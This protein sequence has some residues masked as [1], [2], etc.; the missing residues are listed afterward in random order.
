MKI[1]LV[2]KPIKLKFTF[3]CSLVLFGCT[4][5]QVRDFEQASAEQKKGHFRKAAQLYDQV[6]GRDSS[7]P[8][9]IEAMKE[10]ARITFLEIKDYARAAK[11]YKLV[12][13]HSPEENDRMQAQLQLASLYFEGLQ[14]YANAAIEF[15][16]LAS[17]TSI[18]SERAAHKLSVARSYYYIGNYFQTLS[19]ISEILKLKSDKETEFQAFKRKRFC[20]TEKVYGS[21]QTV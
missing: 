5:S 12:I 4:N 19:E 20:S 6:I 17:S 11:Y 16:K 1:V 18:E 21:R 2:K 13:Q 10:P 3:L 8:I 7:Q 14:D 9:A 15:S